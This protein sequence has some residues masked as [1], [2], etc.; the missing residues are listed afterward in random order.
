MET[1][2]R[3]TSIARVPVD[4]GE[5]LNGRWKLSCSPLAGD[6]F[7]CELDSLQDLGKSSDARLNT[8]AGTV[9]YTKTFDAG[10]GEQRWLDLGTVHGIS[11]VT[12]NGE[13]L[14]VRWY[15][16]HAYDVS[17]V[18]RAGSNDLEVRVTTVLFNYARTLT[19]NEAA[20]RWIGAGKAK[21]TVPAGL[22]GPVR[23][24]E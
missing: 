10:S 2:E 18:V 13:P 3:A 22:V 15:G 23:I 21:R 11:E 16:R 6:D 7:T 14:S 12:L 9:T 24:V 1:G 8:F 4:G 19:D 5:V 20:F 17:E